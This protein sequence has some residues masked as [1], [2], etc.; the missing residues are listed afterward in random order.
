MKSGKI[1]RRSFLKK[2]SISIAA[3]SSLPLISAKSI[4][5][6]YP[7]YNK[8]PGRSVLNFNEDAVAIGSPVYSVIKQMMD[9][10]IK[11][12]TDQTTATAGWEAIFP[13]Q[14]TTSDKIAIKVNASYTLKNTME[15][16]K[17]VAEGLASMLGGTF[18]ASN[19]TIYDHGGPTSLNFQ[20]IYNLSSNI[21]GIKSSNGRDGRSQRDPAA[22]NRNYPDCLNEAKYLIDLPVMKTHQQS[23]SGRLSLC[24]KGHIGTYQSGHSGF[25]SGDLIELRSGVVKDKCVLCIIDAIKGTKSG[26]NGSAQSFPT[27][28]E[29]ISPGTSQTDP[30]TIILST[31]PVSTEHVGRNVFRIDMDNPTYGS[32]SNDIVAAGENAGFGIGDENDPAWDY[33]EIVNGQSTQIRQLPQNK[34]VNNELV[35]FQNKPN[36]AATSTT[37]RFSVPH[38]ARNGNVH[39]AISNLAGRLIRKLTC[40]ANTSECIWDLKD[41]SGSRVP[42]GRY[43]YSVSIKGYSASK[44]LI[45]K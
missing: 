11:M 38:E 39:I 42:V 25:D 34:M 2:S 35:L 18:P 36:P 1:S 26:Y 24:F 15:V 22:G 12:L 4:C 3:A 10:S 44:Q 7:L 45:V 27:W 29:T 13:E 9:E 33:R 16:I 19:I 32:G 23:W 40:N 17:A 37:I 8:W 6:K 43:I 41:A 30:S 14:I 5:A 20:S 21:P 31:D 28:T